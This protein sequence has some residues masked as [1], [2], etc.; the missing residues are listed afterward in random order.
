V[1]QRRLAVKQN[2]P[3]QLVLADG[4]CGVELGKHSN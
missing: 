3:N 1:Q 4:V 2:F